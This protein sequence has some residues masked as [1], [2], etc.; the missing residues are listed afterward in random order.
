MAL[1]TVWSDT[2]SRLI[3]GKNNVF[4]VGDVVVHFNRH[5]HRLSKFTLKQ[6]KQLRTWEDTKRHIDEVREAN[7]QLLRYCLDYSYGVEARQAGF[8]CNADTIRVILQPK[9]HNVADQHNFLNF[10]LN[11]FNF[12][13]KR[14]KATLE[15]KCVFVEYSLER[16]FIKALRNFAVSVVN[17]RVLV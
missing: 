12:D 6:V 2:P 16:E 15:T 4:F 5:D 11:G 3:Y 9:K 13:S 8:V 1:Q 10:C 17:A 7:N 14:V